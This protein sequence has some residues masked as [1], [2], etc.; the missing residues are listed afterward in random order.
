MMWA[1]AKECHLGLKR[2]GATSSIE[3]PEEAQ[4]CPQL[5]F[6]PLILIS[7]FSLWNCE[8]RNFSLF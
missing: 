2:Q 3:P 6:Y 8:R 7:D 1:Q 5:D 4:P